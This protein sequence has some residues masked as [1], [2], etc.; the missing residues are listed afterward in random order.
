MMTSACQPPPLILPADVLDLRRWSSLV[1]RACLHHYGRAPHRVGCCCWPSFAPQPCK[2]PHVLRSSVV[3]IATAFQLGPGPRV[4][5]ARCACG[6]GM[7]DT[8]SATMPN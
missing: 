1:A 6:G 8:A 2:L 5:S 3:T 7:V 4:L